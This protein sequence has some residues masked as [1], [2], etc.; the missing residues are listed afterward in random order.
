[1]SST[2]TDDNLVHPRRSVTKKP[3]PLSNGSLFAP[4]SELPSVSVIIPVKSRER[5]I[6]PLIETLLSQDYPGSLEIILVGDRNDR[7]WMAIGDIISQNKVAIIEITSKSRGRDANRKRNEG[8]RFANG[9]VL[10][11]TDSDMVHYP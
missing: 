7:T 4:L 10:V 2:S 5:T 3:M 9:E 11:L 6:R 1:M 8:L